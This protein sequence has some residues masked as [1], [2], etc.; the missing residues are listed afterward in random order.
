MNDISLWNTYENTVRFLNKLDKRSK[1][2]RDEPDIP[3]KPE[4]KII[5]DDVMVVGI[6]TN[7]NQFIQLSTPIRTD[8]ISVDLDLPSI[9]NS[10][11]I[12]NSKARPMLSS[13]IPITT[14]TDVDKERVDYIK[15]I[16]LETSF[17]NVFRNTIRILLNNYENSKIREKIEKEILK[18]YIIYSEKLQNM[19]HLLRELV[20]EK[21]QFIG[22]ENYYK[23]INEISTC[24]VKDKESCSATPNLC[25]V[26]E[27]NECNLIL[28]EK[29]LMTNKENEPIYYGKMAD[30]LIRYN[31][32]KSFML[33]PQTYLSFG[34]IGYNL[35]DNE[36][37]LIQSLLTKEYFDS[38]IPTITNKYIHSNSY[39]ETQPVITQVYDNQIPSLDHAIGQNNEKKCN[40]V[41]NEKIK[42]TIWKDCFP[43]NYSEI[44]YNFC[45]FNFIIDLIEKKTGNRLTENQIKNELYDEYKK[46]LP[47]YQDKIID[48]LIIEGKKT[49]GDQVHSK[50]LSFLNLISTY[51]YFLTTLDIW[52]LILKYKIPTI[53]IS[54]KWILQTKYEKHQFV[55]YGDKDDKFVFIVIPGF[56]PENV[57]TLKFIKSDENDIFISLDKLNRECVEKIKEDID[58]QITIEDYLKK[59]TKP[60]KTQYEKKKPKTFII[61]SDID[62]PVVKPK[63]KEK[64]LVIEETS[65]VSYAVE[66]KSKKVKQH[67]GNEK[68]KKNIKITSNNASKKNMKKKT[69]LIANSSS[70][71]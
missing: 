35:R 27:N 3:C 48:I 52:L 12:I 28:P 33:Q 36:I 11:Y 29:N 10:N 43:E 9:S 54:Q 58:E 34:N 44:K 65:P 21:I 32:I 1:K 38:L 17:Y 23:L 26:S 46:Y 39:D 18:E 70:T 57:P 30:E 25:A 66:E 40:N 2:R 69:L 41:V 6:L 50:T 61:E 62:E 24:I 16:K 56:R 55:A 59:F 47:Q 67:K 60:I 20:K 7:T 45:T 71:E 13:D 5:E 64:K 68:S 53:F 8:E 4:F 51:N 22:D 31:R 15:K 37:I 19:I 49:L 14:E 63:K 42:S